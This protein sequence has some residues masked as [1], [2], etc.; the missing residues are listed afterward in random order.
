[1]ARRYGQ[2]VVNVNDYVCGRLI[3]SDKRNHIAFL[4]WKQ[5]MK[6]FLAEVVLPR[7]KRIAS[8][9]LSALHIYMQRSRRPRQKSLT[10]AWP[11]F[12]SSINQLQ[13]IEIEYL[14]DNHTHLIPSQASH[15]CN[16]LLFSN[17][18]CR[19]NQ[20][21]TYFC[22]I[23]PL[24][25]NKNGCAASFTSVLLGSNH[26]SGLYFQGS[27]QYLVLRVNV[28]GWTMTSTPAGT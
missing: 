6:H 18:T 19:E 9:T 12:R 2:T 8:G 15:H 13:I 11:I 17:R 28:H 7:E 26:L 24:G 16:E 23:Q 21:S 22:P 3:V 25:P 5:R 1:M 14:G 4:H 27:F 10:L 20:A